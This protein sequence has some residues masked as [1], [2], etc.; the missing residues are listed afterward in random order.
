[1]DDED[2]LRSLNIGS[3]N[4]EKY[5]RIRKNV[6]RAFEILSA[7]NVILMPLLGLLA[8]TGVTGKTSISLYISILILLAGVGGYFQIIFLK[9]MRKYRKIIET[10]WAPRPGSRAIFEGRT[11][12]YFIIATVEMAAIM[13]ILAIITGNYFIIALSAI[14]IV[15]IPALYLARRDTAKRGYT[16]NH[17]VRGDVDEIA[18]KIAVTF[19]GEKKILIK[20]KANRAYRIKVRVG[21]EF[22][23]NVSRRQDKKDFTQIS[24]GE[25]KKDDI[26]E[27]RKLIYEIE[28]LLA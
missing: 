11:S 10:T 23:I 9:A 17:I 5:K 20:S 15:L 22:D 25:V 19:N 12:I 8:Y 4:I 18:E 3:E 27:V 16:I 7:S 1:M 28:K 13:V 2:I 21:S 24:I 14:I 6:Y 26:S